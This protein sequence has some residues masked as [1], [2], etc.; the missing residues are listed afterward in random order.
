[1]TNSPMTMSKSSTLRAM[2]VRHSA[3]AANDAEARIAAGRASTAQ[4]DSSIGRPSAMPSANTTSRNA[5]A[6]IELRMRA[7]SASPRATSGTRIGVARMPSYVFWTCSLKWTFK[8]TIVD[9]TVHAAGC[10]KTRRHERA[11]GHAVDVG[12][13][14]SQEV[15]VEETI[16]DRTVHA[17]GCE[18]TRRHERAVGHAV[19]VGNQRSQAHSNPEQVEH[20]FK[21]ARDDRHPD[22]LAH[23][24]VALHDPARSCQ[25]WHP[26]RERAHGPQRGH[27]AAL[28]DAISV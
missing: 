21:E 11:V 2:L 14:R 15:D 10:E 16:V 22:V 13:Q 7:H 5:P 26:D 3:I 18:K 6:Y 28:T 20:R 17:A 12:N 4:R 1:M 27:L 25:R 24:H 19:D 9:R 8:E 23:D